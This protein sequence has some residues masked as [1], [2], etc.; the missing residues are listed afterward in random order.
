MSFYT[1]TAWADGLNHIITSDALP[2][3]ACES[4]GTDHQRAVYNFMIEQLNNEAPT[5][6]AC[7]A[8]LPVVERIREPIR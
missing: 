5:C 1:R 3:S 2:W 7:V 4:H 6:L 8:M